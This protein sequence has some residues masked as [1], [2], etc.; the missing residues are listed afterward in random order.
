MAIKYKPTEEQMAIIQDENDVVVTAKPGSGKTFT[1][2][3]KIEYLSES[4]FDYQGIIAISFTRKASSELSMRCKR[5]NIPIKQSFYGTIDNFYI[6]QII[7]PFAKQITNTNIKLEIKEKLDDYPEYRLL[8]KLKK[9]ID[10]ELETL[11]IKSLRNGYIFLEI[12]GETAMYI[13]DK[14]QDCI[15]Y[16]KSRYTH[17]FIDEYQDCGAIQHEIFMKLVNEGIIGIAVGDMDQ[18]IYGF[19]GRESKYLTELL[20]DIKF[21]HYEISKNHRC[22]EAISAYSLKMLGIDSLKPSK[23][24][25]VTEVRVNGSDIEIMNMVDKY[26]SKIKKKYKVENNNEVA[27]LCRSNVTAQRASEYL[28]TKNKLFQETKLD[29]SSSHWA[30]LFNEMLKCY[31]DVKVYAIDFVERYI[32]NELNNKRFIKAIKIIKKIFS[33]DVK[34]IFNRIDLFS[35]FALLIYPEYHNDDTV[36]ILKEI[37]QDQN[38]LLNYKPAESD[39]ICIL[40]LHKSKG[41]EYKIIFHLDLYKWIFPRENI[42]QKDY[43]QSLNLHYVGVT[44]AI[45]VCYLMQGTKRYRPGKNDYINTVASPF[46][47]LNGLDGFRE[48]S[49]WSV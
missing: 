47:T 3:E 20:K 34:E 22:H 8:M 26:I 1:I 39:E 27:I 44:R 13:L 18:A 30:R 43:I 16:L 24:K 46:L 29:S 33:E 32:D 21:S 35:E 4:L 15:L 41:L 10:N 49:N 25:R 5:K 37:L 36:N 40:T 9:E 28:K 38:Q 14:V 7:H 2:V 31:F 48:T 6:S 45:E 12:S 19:A 17:V 42:S 11:L 23:E